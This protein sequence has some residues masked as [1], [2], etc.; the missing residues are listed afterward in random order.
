MRNHFTI[1]DPAP[2]SSSVAG[3]RAARW[4]Q[5]VVYDLDSTVANTRQRRQL[6][7]SINPDSTWEAYALACAADEPMEASIL[8]LRAFA[9]LGHSCHAVSARPAVAAELTARWLVEQQVPH[10]SLRLRR[11]TDSEDSGQFKLDTLVELTAQGFRPYLFLEDL[12]AV[13][14]SL[15]V[16]VPVLA[17]NPLYSDAVSSQYEHP[18]RPSGH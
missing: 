2:H 3:Q 17:V 4:C 18:V 10:H 15:A 7:P 8:V 6:C 16:V 5:A 1:P 14:R 11:P 13:V 9:T 12:P